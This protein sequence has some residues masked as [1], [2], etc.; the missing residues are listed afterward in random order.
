MRTDALVLFSSL[1]EN[2]EL[3]HPVNHGDEP[4]DQKYPVHCIGGPPAFHKPKEIVGKE[5]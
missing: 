5:K 2:V 3:H 1:I 4:D